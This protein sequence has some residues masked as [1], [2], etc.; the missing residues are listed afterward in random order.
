M[1]QRMIPPRNDPCDFYQ[2]V[3]RNKTKCSDFMGNIYVSNDK[4]YYSTKTRVSGGMFGRNLFS[5]A[6]S[7]S[8]A[9]GEIV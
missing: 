2:N 6:N 3:R 1:K 9:D 5:D 7:V 8:R 4:V